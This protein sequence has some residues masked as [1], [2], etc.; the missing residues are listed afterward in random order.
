MTGTARA[1]AVFRRA[2]SRVLGF[3]A[4]L[5]IVFFCG[6]LIFVVAV[7]RT[8]PKPEQLWYRGHSSV[9]ARVRIG[10]C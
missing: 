2:V 6:S 7:C 10:S 5:L 1:R 4:K 8:L 3:F 9:V